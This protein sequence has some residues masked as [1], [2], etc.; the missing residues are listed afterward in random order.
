[1]TGHGSG[2]PQRRTL[3]SVR[4]RTT[5]LACAVVAV[6][7]VVASVG[8]IATLEHSLST[9]RDDLS[10]AQLTDLAAQAAD[11]ALPTL[12]TDIGDNSVAQVFLETGEVVTASTGLAGKGPI[13]STMPQSSTPRLLTLRDVPDDF[14]TEDYRVLGCTRAEPFRTSGGARRRQPGVR[15]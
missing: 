9:N 5:L 13:L 1:M 4:A 11:G 14:E 6:T 12:V 7:L 10:R 15:G 2:L 3:S 8:L